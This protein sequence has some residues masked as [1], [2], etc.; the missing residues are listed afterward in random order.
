M[1]NDMD[2]RG[3]KFLDWYIPLRAADRTGFGNRMKM[4]EPVLGV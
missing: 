3:E 1:N 4:Y 2:K